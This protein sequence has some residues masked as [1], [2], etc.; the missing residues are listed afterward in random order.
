MGAGCRPGAICGENH[1]GKRS[2]PRN[3]NGFPGGKSFGREGILSPP[4]NL[5]RRG[6]PVTPPQAMGTPGC[7]A[8]CGGWGG[9]EAFWR[10]VVL[11]ST[12]SRALRRF[13]PKAAFPP[14]LCRGEMKA[15][16]YRINSKHLLGTNNPIIKH[17]ENKKPF[18][19]LLTSPTLAWVTQGRWNWA[20]CA[21]LTE[22]RGQGW[23]RH[24][25]QGSRHGPELAELRERRDTA[26][27]RRVGGWE[28]LHGAGLGSVVPEGPFQLGMFCGSVILTAPAPRGMQSQQ[29]RGGDTMRGPCP[30]AAGWGCSS[31][32]PGTPG[33]AWAGNCSHEILPG[34]GRGCAPH[35]SSPQRCRATQSTP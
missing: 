3:R 10:T 12:V 11:R 4:V 20:G 34:V 33:E 26:L 16:P 9:G 5:L 21:G 19:L 2:E 6:Y 24:S 22:Q 25:S 27:S 18:G 15:I 7:S 1:A 8:R 35:T 32:V 17:H 28:V 29:L 30:G 23:A 31:P 14:Q 13:A